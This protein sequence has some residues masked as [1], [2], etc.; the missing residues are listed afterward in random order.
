MTLRTPQGDAGRRPRHA[1]SETEGR[2]FQSFD[3]PLGELSKGQQL[4][5]L[6]LSQENARVPVRFCSRG[7][8]LIARMRLSEPLAG[9]RPSAN[10]R[11]LVA[12]YRAGHA[13]AYTTPARSG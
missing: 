5:G 3:P 1:H 10:L 7:C 9:R 12:I 13:E 8:C 11:T 6:S 2:P 4:H